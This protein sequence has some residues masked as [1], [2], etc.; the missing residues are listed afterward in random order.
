MFIRKIVIDKYK[1]LENIS[2]N[3]EHIVKNSVF[4]IISLNGGGKSTLLQFIFT[5]LHCPFRE[6]RFEYIRNFLQDFVIENK[7]NKPTKIATFELEHESQIIELEFYCVPK[8]YKNLNFD[9]ILAL[10]ELEINKIQNKKLIDN[11]TILNRLEDDIKNSRI[12]DVSIKR[13]L[14]RFVNNSSQERILTSALDNTGY[15]S[16]IQENRKQFAS[17]LFSDEVLNSMTIKA[18]IEK[19]K[20]LEALQ[21]ENLEYA[22]HFNQNK[23]ILLYKSNVKYEV[24]AEISDKVYLATPNT[25]VLHFISSKELSYLFTKDKYTYTTYENAIRECQKN[26]AG[27]FTYDFSVI[28]LILEAFQKARDAD[29]AKAIETGNYGNEINKTTKEL[30]N[31]LSNKIIS[32]DKDF[33]SVSFKRKDSQINLSPKDLSH[34]ELKKLSIYIWL[35]AKTSNDSVVLMDEVD[36]GLHPAWQ[37]ELC[38]N[39]Q[40]WSIGSQ[41]LLATHSPQIISTTH[42][43]NLVVLAKISETSNNSTSEQFSEAPLDSDLNTIVKTIMGGEYIPKELQKLHKKYRSFVVEKSLDSEEAEKIKQQILEYESENSSFFQNIKF[44][45]A[46]GK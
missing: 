28:S 38:D 35:K 33:K 39:L 18:E 2:I 43:K 6:N 11:I 15:L 20:L 1:V 10:K 29:F 44:E 37:H 32:I 21:N 34:G 14:S 8:N 30:S 4:P 27:L 41:F 5:F 36:M 26:L 25:Q 9:A 19:K 13:E 3:F 42:Y 40:E 12:S 45:L 46:F 23:N 7:D 22:L 31:L 24:L 16:I 17:D